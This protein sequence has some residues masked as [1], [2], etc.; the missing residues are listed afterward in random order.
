MPL[1]NI[2]VSLLPVF[3]VL[4]ALIFL[5]SFKLIRFQSVLWAILIGCLAAEVSL[6]INLY[7]FPFLSL[8]SSLVRR[9]AAPFT[10]ECLKAVFI[11]YMIRSNRIGF[12]VDAAI[13]GFAVGSGFSFIENVYYLQSVHDSNILLW[14][15]RGFGTA[16]MHSG[17]TALFAIISKSLID[18]HPNHRILIYI[19]GFILAAALHSF[20]NHFLLGPVLLTLCQLI[21]LP[22]LILLVFQQS[23]TS[24]RNWL[25]IG[26]ES[27]M[28]LLDMIVTGN[29][30][31]TRVGKYL[32]SLKNKFQGAVLA[33]ML[34][35]LRLHIELTVRAKGILMMKE[36]GFQLKPDP[37]I[38]EKITELKYLDKSIGK[39][40]KLALFPFLQLSSR[41]LW[42][43]YILSGS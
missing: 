19:P 16:V 31:E 40:G 7:M 1:I 12:M 8:D 17:T 6:L 11:V 42:Q 3:L 23:E 30:A 39:T 2:L 10:E 32:E 27:D 5:D 18:R 9:Y 35:Y 24:L 15:I 29:I 43:L 14:I 25:E 37:E 22:L 33:D 20:F 4:L 21:V 26:L 38:R 36:A 41:D 28:H 34:C 13:Y